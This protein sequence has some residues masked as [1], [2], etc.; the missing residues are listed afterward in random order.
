MFRIQKE[1]N[2]SSLVLVIAFSILQIVSDF[3]FRISD[4]GILRG[5]G[6]LAIVFAISASGQQ[7]T[8]PHIG[9]AYPAG[10]RQGTTFLVKVGGQFLDGVTNAHVT[11]AGVKASVVEFMKPM[12]PMQANALREK[13][14][15]LQDKRQVAMNG[16]SEPPG[17]TNV[18]WTVEDQRMIMEIR[19]KLATF[20]RRPQNPAIAETAT[21][22]VTLA[23]DAEPGERELRL[24]TQTGLSNPLIFCMGQLPEFYKKEPAVG[25]E[26]RRGQRPNNNE[27][28]RAAPTET[29]ISLPAIVNGQILPGG[30]DRFRFSARAGQKLVIAVSARELIPYLADAVPGWFQATLT[31]YDGQGHELTYDDRYRFHPD[32]V[33]AYEVPKAGEYVAEIRDSIYRGR[34]DFVYRIEIGELPF[35]TGI[36][37]LG[38]PAGSETAVEVTGWNL[39]TTNVVQDAQGPGVYSISVRK[40]AFISN[41]VPFTVDKLPEV[42]EAEPNDSTTNAQKLTLPIIV[43]G[44]IERAED[45]DVFQFEGHAGQQVVAEVDARRLG[46]PLDSTLELTDANGRR[47]A[48]NDDYEDKGSGLNTHHADSYL[49]VTLPVDGTYYLRLEDAQHQG[50]PEYAYRLRVSAPMPDF[51]LRVA[52]SSIGA[53]AGL[54]SPLTVYAL[55][56]D[57]FSNAIEIALKDAPPGFKLSGGRIPANQDQVRVT[58]TAPASP[59]SEPVSL[60]LEGRATNQ[61]LELV[62]LAVPAEDMM[63]AFA[64]RH[65][66][67][68][69]ELEVTVVGRP[70]PRQMVK[71]LS[72]T[73]VKLVAG[74]TA[75]V[76]LGTPS[77]AFA[78]RWELELSNPPE[79]IAIQK[80]AAVEGG[81]EIWLTADA[82]KV[83]PG[84]KG[85]L[86]VNLAASKTATGTPKGKGPANARRGSAGTLPAI[87]FE[88]VQ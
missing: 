45:R 32:P 11:G 67:P 51:A 58:L 1:Q 43:N 72:P 62:R 60:S 80:V 41:R 74:E 36:F 35:V 50:G 65:L 57:A 79:G 2:R 83:K 29:A 37:P 46:S 39:P 68:S 69:Q 10:G 3:G 52:P 12:T 47:V 19:E 70:L 28:L 13:L 71:I 64:Y 81:A 42:L 78:E 49:N 87:P 14:K 55:R 27:P 73:P 30:V 26:P 63:Q 15:E 34:E 86:I 18:T 8:T 76:R 23:P 33:I 48:F 20:Q 59:Q 6:W 77:N 9:Y 16:K 40:G 82:S 4:L 22:R 56:R 61:G 53:R 66:V 84:L 21:I 17:G 24:G 25:N 5:F 7:Q 54:S 75:R 44:R 85:N 38:G 88:V 31:L